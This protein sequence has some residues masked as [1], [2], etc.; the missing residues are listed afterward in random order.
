[1]ERMSS[2]WLLAAAFALG[3]CQN[4]AAENERSNVTAQSAVPA[5][6]VA[7]VS[8]AGSASMR[9]PHVDPG[10]PE[11]PL[12]T[13][14]IADLMPVGH[15]QV[16]GTV[17]FTQTA[18]GEVKVH[19]DVTGLPAGAHAYHVHVFGD[20]S[21]EDGNTAGT[22]FNFQGS[23]LHPPSDIKLITGNLGELKAD[24]SGKA[25]ADA[26][27]E[28]VSLTGPFTIL[29]RSVIVH[30]KGNDMTSPPMGAAGGRIACGVIGVKSGG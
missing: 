1:M 10:D 6:T 5:A 25:T 27:I 3:A 26:T 4:G 15:S 11:S 8:D 12:V 17:T 19:A 16:K 20:C 14:A 24:A 18:P 28:K 22:H 7:S 13:H 21:G 9:E 29:G 30:E 2:L 23:S